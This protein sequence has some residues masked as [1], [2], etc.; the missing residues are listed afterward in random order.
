MFCVDLF[1]GSSFG[2]ASSPDWGFQERDAVD[3]SQSVSRIIQEQ[4]RWEHHLKKEFE[5]MKKELEFM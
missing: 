1:S 2:M 5:F 3:S 4:Y